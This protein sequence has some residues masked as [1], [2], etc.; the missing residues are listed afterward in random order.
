MCRRKHS[1]RQPRG[2][3]SPAFP[4]E[5][6]VCVQSVRSTHKEIVVYSGIRPPPP[7]P[8]LHW[9]VFYLLLVLVLLCRCSSCSRSCSGHAWQADSV[10]SKTPLFNVFAVA[11]NV[12]STLIEHYSISHTAYRRRL[13][14]YR[15]TATALSTQADHNRGAALLRPASPL[16]PELHARCG[17]FSC[18]HHG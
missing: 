6:S 10:G 14:V 13:L 9:S 8:V 5:S 3:N 7:S 2:V 12:S 18:I 15:L 11:V 4:Q 16:P 17:K 1:W